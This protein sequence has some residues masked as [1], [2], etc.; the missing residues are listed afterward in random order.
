MGSLIGFN[1]MENERVGNT[2]KHTDGCQFREPYYKIREAGA[3]AESRFLRDAETV[4]ARVGLD[5]RINGFVVRIAN[6]ELSEDF[7]MTLMLYADETSVHDPTGQHAGSDFPALSGLVE[8]KEYWDKFRRQWKVILNDFAA[9]YFH[10]K[11]F[12]FEACK[13]PNSPYR[14][15]SME[16]KQG[17][18]FELAML[19]SESIVPVGGASPAKHHYDLG[20]GID[21]FEQTADN[22]FKSLICMLDVHWPRYSG[23]VALFIEKSGNTRWTVPLAKVHREYQGKDSRIGALVFPKKG[24]PLHSEGLQ[25]AD[26]SSKI[27]RDEAKEYFNNDEKLSAGVLDFIL[28]KNQ[29]PFFRAF[30]RRKW[31][32]L[33]G[34]LR[35]HELETVAS[36][37]RQGIKMKYEPL[38]LFPWKQYG[39]QK[40]D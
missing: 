1:L 18:I 28:G 21:P 3:A 37:R 30:E 20:T 35:K 22:F 11:E 2:K 17:F 12:G 7:F 32:W 8:A 29:D 40:P 23:S 25:A 13:Q 39:F 4:T 5:G 6:A 9:P 19:I 16:K 31:R 24:D 26:L 36:W 34:E 33:A 15:W 14:T 27:F 10:F 38:K